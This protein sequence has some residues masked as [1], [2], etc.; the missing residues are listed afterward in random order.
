MD[1]KTIYTVT[2]YSENHVGLLNQISIIYTRRQLNIESFSASA[3][4]IKGVH[5]FTIVTSCDRETIENVVKQ[6][7]KIVDVIKAFYYSD[8]E[9]IF[10]EV[11]L[12][13][14]STP[15]LL[16]EGG[17]EPLIRKYGVRIL[18]INETFTVLE[19]TGQ[20]AETQQ[21]FEDLEKYNVLQFV[22]SGRIVII[23]SCVEQVSLFLENREKRRGEIE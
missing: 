12:Y 13:K 1:Q 21:L 6:I 7:E 11:A 10:Q 14:I 22:R 17:M 8:D 3:S 15:K 20:Q 18:D 16:S 4:A 9:V 2:V 23:K 5:K 19:K